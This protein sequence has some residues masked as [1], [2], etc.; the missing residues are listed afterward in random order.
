[1]KNTRCFPLIM[2]FVCLLVSCSNNP[3]S[4]ENKP[5]RPGDSIGEM[6]IVSATSPVPHVTSFCSREELGI[7]DCM[8][9]KIGHI[10]ITQGWEEETMEEL[11]KA[12]SSSS[13]EL[14]VDGRNVDVNAFLSDTME[15]EDRVVRY[16]SIALQ[17]PTPGKHTVRWA[18]TGV[19]EEDFDETWVFTVADNAGF[20]QG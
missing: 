16:W 13:W 19:P 11:E 9:P 10:G 20:D 17:S 7:G 5:L 12:W 2:F 18:I 8:V 15:L 14:V 6:A 1:M 3:Q 4:A